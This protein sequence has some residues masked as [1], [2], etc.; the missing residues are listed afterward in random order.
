MYY[1]IRTSLGEEIFDNWGD[2]L[3]FRDLAP[4][5]AKFKKFSSLEDAQ[6]FLRS[7]Q[8]EVEGSG[9]KR[10]TPAQ[11]DA[12]PSA[13]VKP[14]TN[15]VPNYNWKCN[16][17]IA[18]TDGSFNQATGYWGYGVVLQDE[19]GCE[20]AIYSGNGTEY[21]SSRNVTGDIY[22][23]LRTIQAAIQHRCKSIVI[24]P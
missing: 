17:V 24:K 12:A 8:S 7:S 3:R 6:A 1:A 9:K 15:P 21:A 4:K 23:A 22:G 13:S 18:Y 5:N 2:C 19:N 20:L 11:Y 14:A 16:R 10:Y